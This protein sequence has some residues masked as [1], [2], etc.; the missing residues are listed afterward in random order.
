MRTKAATEK[1]LKRALGYKPGQ[2]LPKGKQIDHSGMSG[3]GGD[4]IGSVGEAVVS[5]L[6]IGQIHGLMN[7]AYGT[8]KDKGRTGSAKDVQD[9]REGLRTALFVEV[10]VSGIL[11]YAFE[12]WLAVGVG[13]GLS[14]TLFSIGTYALNSGKAE[15]VAAPQSVEVP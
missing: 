4:G 1:Y 14:V 15:S 3:P 13:L 7:P 6:S 11:G 2:W 12:S 8:L 9:A 5:A 10:G